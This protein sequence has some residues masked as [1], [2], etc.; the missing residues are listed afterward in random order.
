MEFSV[1]LSLYKKERPAYLRQSLDSILAQ[2]MPPSEIVIVEDGELTD[3]LYNVVDEYQRKCACLKIVKL[4]KNQGLGK[5]LNEGLKHCSFDIVARMDTDDISKPERFEKQIKEFENDPELCAVSCWID[6]FYDSPNDIRST[7]EVPETME[8][9]VKF[10]KKR[11][12]L[13]HPAVMFKKEKTEKVG[14]YIPFHLF[15][16][17]FLWVRLILKGCKIKN[18]Q[19]SLLIFRANSDMYKRRGGLNYALTEIKFQKKLRELGYIN[20]WEMMLNIIIR[21]T[22]RLI[23]NKLRIIVYKTFLRKKK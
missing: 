16:D 2:T 4:E 20:F 7:R 19:G 12:P 21:M 13:N 22:T 23:P 17:Y 8:E 1:L 10:G 5:A 18:I 6:E 11:S 3:E 14:S 9:I 15:E